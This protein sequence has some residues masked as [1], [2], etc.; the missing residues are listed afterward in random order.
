[1]G[2]IELKPCPFCG[3]YVDVWKHVYPNGES[4]YEPFAWH[5]SWCALNTVLWCGDYETEEELAEHW[6]RREYDNH[7]GES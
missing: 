2:L 4:Y 3:C 5:Q 1:M 7:D 6:N